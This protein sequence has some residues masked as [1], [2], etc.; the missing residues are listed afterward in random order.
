MN[1]FLSIAASLSA[2]S[3]VALAIGML[4]LFATTAVLILRNK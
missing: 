1:R 4:G 3:D 2:F